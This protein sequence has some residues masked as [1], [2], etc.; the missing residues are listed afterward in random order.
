MPQG[1]PMN[2]TTKCENCRFF[3]RVATLSHENIGLEHSA[4]GAIVNLI[5]RLMWN[6]FHSVGVVSGHR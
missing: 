4:V 2:S 6:T 3:L 5:S 1:L